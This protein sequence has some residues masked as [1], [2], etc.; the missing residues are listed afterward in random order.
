MLI[1]WKIK[2][3]KVSS[4][5]QMEAGIRDFHTSGRLFPEQ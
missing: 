4:E 1:I 3:G 5:G 2:G